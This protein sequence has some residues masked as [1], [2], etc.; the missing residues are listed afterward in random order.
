MTAQHLLACD[1]KEIRNLLIKCRCGGALTIPLPQVNLREHVHCMGCDKA[2]WGGPEDPRYVRLLG[3]IRS[4]TN[5]QGLE[6]DDVAVC[7]LNRGTRHHIEEV[8]V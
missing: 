3:L 2:L 5:W 8:K 6:Q 7:F 1:F 4:L